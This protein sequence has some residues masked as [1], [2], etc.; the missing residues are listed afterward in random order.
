MQRTTE[1]LQKQAWTDSLTGMPNRA[2]LYDL[3]D[4]ALLLGP[5]VVAVLDLDGFK[6][7]NDSLGHA[8]GDE[9]AFVLPTCGGQRQ[10]R[11]FGADVLRSLVGPIAL[12]SRSLVL[13]G[14]LGLVLSEDGDT[15]ES[16]LR[17]AD[18]AMYAAKDAGKDRLRMFEPSMRDELLARFAMED[19]LR[20]ALLAGDIVPWF[21][22]VVDLETGLMTGVEASRV[23]PTQGSSSL[24]RSSCRWPSRAGWSPSSAARSFARPAHTPPRGTGRHP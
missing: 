11:A 16:L 5:G 10:A 14:S 3:I 21:Q 6:A 9:F 1:E 7:V 2:R 23:G 17:N 22:P 24:R 8:T 19:D 13:T 15:P 20:V 12:G 4:E 18:V